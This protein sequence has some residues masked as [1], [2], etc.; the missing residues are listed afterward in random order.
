MIFRGVSLVLNIHDSIILN[1]T[2]NAI[3]YRETGRKSYIKFSAL[4]D[5]EKVVIKIEDNGVGID[6][7]KFGDKIFGMYKTFHGNEDARGIGLFITKNQ[8]ETMGGRISV[9]SVPGES[10][11]FEITL[12]RGDKIGG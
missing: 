7:N 5:P 4:R 8:V 11:V 10:T 1:L 6:M 2:T 9:F 3:K 12:K